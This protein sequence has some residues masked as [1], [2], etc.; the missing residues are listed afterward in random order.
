MVKDPERSTCVDS[1]R[2]AGVG[3]SSRRLRTE[4]GRR[5][6]IRRMRTDDREL[7]EAA[8]D[9]L[10]ERSR[11]F[12]FASPLPRPSK[13]MLDHLMDLDDHRHVA[14]AALTPDQRTIV[15]VARYVR[16]ADDVDTAEVAVAIADAWQRVGVGRLLMS[17]L[18]MDASRAGVRSLVAVTLS[19]NGGAK[20]LAHRVGF[21]PTGSSGLYTDYR[22][23]LGVVSGAVGPPDPLEPRGDQPLTLPPSRPHQSRRGPAAEPHAHNCDADGSPHSTPV[24]RR[25]ANQPGEQS[26]HHDAKDHSDSDPRDRQDPVAQGGLTT[27]PAQPSREQTPAH[28]RKRESSVARWQH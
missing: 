22:L 10:S 19:Q 5:F 7:L 15:G 28:D 2:R 23:Q 20:A 25:P 3:M 16:L 17:R 12:R 14:Y 6:A 18:V 1:T 11:Y 21:A 26:G 8:L 9:G 24:Q 27:G 13:G 4:D